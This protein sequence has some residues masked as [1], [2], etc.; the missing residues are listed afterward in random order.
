M[1]QAL[2]PRGVQFCRARLAVGVP[3]GGAYIDDNFF[4]LW[5][6]SGWLGQPQQSPIQGPDLA[7][8]DWNH[9]RSS[10]APGLIYSRGYQFAVGHRFFSFT[11]RS[12]QAS[13]GSP[14][15]PARPRKTAVG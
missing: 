14:R 11:G 2:G 5:S 8:P 4:R 9:E 6:R 15:L 12:E 1:G 7:G 10:P 3:G 13:A